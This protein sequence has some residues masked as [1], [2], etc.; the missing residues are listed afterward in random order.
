MKEPIITPHMEMMLELEKLGVIERVR[1]LSSEEE[2]EL[3]PLFKRQFPKGFP[4][5]GTILFFPSEDVDHERDYFSKEHEFF[6][7]ATKR[8]GA[9]ADDIVVVLWNTMSYLS[10]EVPIQI[11]SD[12]LEVFLTPEDMYIMPH[13]ARWCICYQA[14]GD[15]GLGLASE[16]PLENTP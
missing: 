3:V 5:R 11:L 7:Q 14:E 12:H 8:V 2:K 4:Y 15:M 1:V 9:G 10:V 16:T 13:D 6:E